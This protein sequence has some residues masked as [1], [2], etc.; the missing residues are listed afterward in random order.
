MNKTDLSIF[1]LSLVT[2]FL[3]ACQTS[4]EPNTVKEDLNSY[5][6]LVTKNGSDQLNEKDRQDCLEVV[7]AANLNVLGTK[8]V[9]YRRCLIDK[10]YVLLS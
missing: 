5:R 4:K 2:L 7:K 1:S 3:T 9:A 6:V 10:G 8:V